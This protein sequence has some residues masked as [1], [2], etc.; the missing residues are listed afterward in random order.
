ML[1]PKFYSSLN[2]VFIMFYNK[3]REDFINFAGCLHPVNKVTK[4]LRHNN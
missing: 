4:V 2:T 3:S 1:A